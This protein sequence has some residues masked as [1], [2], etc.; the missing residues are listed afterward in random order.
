MCLFG[1]T[2]RFDFLSSLAMKQF[3]AALVLSLIIVPSTAAAQ[4][5]M[6]VA[7]ANC[8][9]V[10]QS[11]RTAVVD[12]VEIGDTLERGEYSM[13][14]NSRYYG[15]PSVSDG[16]VYMRIEDEIYRVDWRSHEVLE[17]VT[18]QANRRW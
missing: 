2:S 15:L 6:A 3:A 9:T 8:V 18:D 4:C 5:R 10:P 13:L 12:P 11:A 1:L 17:K 14:M 7:G 16:W